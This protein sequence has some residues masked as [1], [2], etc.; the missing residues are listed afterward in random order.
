MSIYSEFAS[1]YDMMQYDVDYERWVNGIIKI[2]KEH[3]NQAKTMLELA[4]GTG[5]LAI[6]ISK[7]GFITEALDISEDMLSVAQ[8]KAYDAHAKVRFYHQDMITFNTKKTYD[9]IFC[10]CDGMNYIISDEDMKCVFEN[11]KRHLTPEGILIF[12][13]SSKYK[14]SEV[15]GN[16]TFAETFEHE[17]YIWENEYD[18]TRNLLKFT[19]TL[20]KEDEDGYQRFE[21]SHTQRAYDIE[22]LKT[23]SEP[24]FNLVS[25]LD[26]DSFENIQAHSNR[27]CLIMTPK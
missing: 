10:M 6:G 18:H 7:K 23:L 25:V 19:L 1:V 15:I 17:A 8:S 12:D 24:S 26:G 16:H 13:I 11:I 27:I 9:V 14:L 4:C 3:N 2:A 20:F 21:E 5:T 22:T